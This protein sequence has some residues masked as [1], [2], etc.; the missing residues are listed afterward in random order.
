MAPRVRRQAPDAP[1]TGLVYASS[2]CSFAEV[3]T[4]VLQHILGFLDARKDRWGAAPR[5]W[6]PLLLP[7]LLPFPEAAAP[8]SPAL[9]S[10]VG[11]VLRSCA[12][13]GTTVCTALS[14]AA[15][16]RQVAG[17]LPPF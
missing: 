17:A 15:R 3:P 7:P 14:C 8:R 6:A 1:G 4:G 13:S 12:A 5:A 11:T 16:L 10:P 9:R 2:A